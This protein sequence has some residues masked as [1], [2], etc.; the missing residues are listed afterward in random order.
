MPNNLMWTVHNMII[1]CPDLLIGLQCTNVMNLSFF[2]LCLLYE[3]CK[4]LLNDY[5][6]GI[7]NTCCSLKDGYFFLQKS[8][9]YMKTVIYLLSS[10]Y[11][12]P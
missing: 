6:V 12:Y 1:N 8:M 5:P 2:C 3:S 10:L 11:N 9:A 7:L 4:F